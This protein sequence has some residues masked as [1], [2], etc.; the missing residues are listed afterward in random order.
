VPGGDGTKVSARDPR[1]ETD[2]GPLASD[3]QC[4]ACHED[5]EGSGPRHPRAYIH[6]LVNANEV[7]GESLLFAHNLFQ[8]AQVVAAAR[9]AIQTDQLTPW[10][11]WMRETYRI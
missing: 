4:F 11:H 10:T 1:W 9:R 6:H 7:L 8:L 2:M 5:R 3:C